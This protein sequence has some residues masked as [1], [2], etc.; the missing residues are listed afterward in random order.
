MKIYNIFNKF[1]LSYWNPPGERF[2][3]FSLLILA[4]W[5]SFCL[6]YSGS[7][8]GDIDWVW[9]WIAGDLYIL[10]AI[11]VGF[12]FW[13]VLCWGFTLSMLLCLEKR[14]NVE[15]L[16]SW[17]VEYAG[18]IGIRGL[19]LDRASI[20]ISFGFSSIEGNYLVLSKRGRSWGRIIQIMSRFFGIKI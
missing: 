8:K 4:F 5:C 13:S 1:Y 10:S 3:L 20:L 2:K 17:Q 11:L 12:M 18:A 16:Q 7:N 14:K 9:I 6:I 19:S 15:S